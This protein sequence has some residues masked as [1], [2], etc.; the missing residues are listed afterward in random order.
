MPS[1]QQHVN[2]MYSHRLSNCAANSSS[3][4]YDEQESPSPHIDKSSYSSSNVVSNGHYAQHKISNTKRLS[5][6]PRGSQFRSRN[7]TKTFPGGLSERQ[8]ANPSS[9]LTSN[10]HSPSLLNP[11]SSLSTYPTAYSNTVQETSSKIDRDGLFDHYRNSQPTVS[12]R[13]P[14]TKKMQETDSKLP[15]VVG[16][17]SVHINRSD[18]LQRQARLIQESYTDTDS[19]TTTRCNS[20]ENYYL[21]SSEDTGSSVC[22]SNSQTP[23]R[24]AQSDPENSFNAKNH[25]K[26]D[27]HSLSFRLVNATHNQPITTGRYNSDEDS[28]RSSE[29]DEQINYYHTEQLTGNSP[30]ECV[31]NDDNS[32]VK[33]DTDSGQSF[34]KASGPTSVNDVPH[35]VRFSNGGRLNEPN[36]FKQRRVRLQS[37]SQATTLNNKGPEYKRSKTFPLNGPRALPAGVRTGFKKPLTVKE[38]NVTNSR[39]IFT[40]RDKI[41]KPEKNTTKAKPDISNSTKP[42]HGTAKSTKPTHSTAKSTK[43]AYGIPNSTKPA[44]GGSNTFAAADPLPPIMPIGEHQD[45]VQLKNKTEKEKNIEPTKN[46]SST[47][48]SECCHC[49]SSTIDTVIII[50]M[51]ERG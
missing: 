48:E 36:L 27:R 11:S 1:E 16:Y 23:V 43:P 19:N 45:D 9:L 28:E 34:N 47:A 37:E 51:C 22:T 8:A 41:N 40:K 35:N 38:T 49:H 15:Q 21:T 7:M 32:V 18:S 39:Q 50:C 31:A 44:H 13:S 12:N 26:M 24:Q 17:R 33:V 6:L 5:Q 25:D 30:K 42:A 10:I 14:K 2:G 3:K 4:N 20:S 29:D 46:R